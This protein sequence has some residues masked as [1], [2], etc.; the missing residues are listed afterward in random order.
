M[1]DSACLTFRLV[2][3][4]NTQKDSFLVVLCLQPMHT[5]VDERVAEHP[6]LRQG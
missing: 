5:A 2:R 1:G 3:N 4:R 6:P